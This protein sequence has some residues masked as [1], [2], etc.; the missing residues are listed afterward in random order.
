VAKQTKVAEV[1]KGGRFTQV[2]GKWL[3]ALPI[4]DVAEA[5]RTI[6]VVVKSGKTVAFMVEGMNGDASK[7]IFAVLSA[8]N[9]IVYNGKRLDK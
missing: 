7:T 9:E 2:D 4:G 6:E 5:G 1:I 3:V 8:T